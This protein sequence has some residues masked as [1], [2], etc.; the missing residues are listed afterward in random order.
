MTKECIAR[1]YFW[2]NVSDVTFS[3]SVKESVEHIRLQL[4]PAFVRLNKL[5]KHCKERT[6][7][8]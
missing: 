2:L 7:R 5:T 6:R 1:G 8:A 4:Q 3:R